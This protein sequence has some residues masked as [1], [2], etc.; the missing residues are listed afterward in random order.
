L[1]Q[2]AIQ[3]QSAPEDSSQ[4][5]AWVAHKGQSFVPIDAFGDGARSVFKLLV[6]LHTLVDSVSKDEP[7]LLIWE[8]PELF[9]NPKTLGLLLRELARLVKPKPI[10]L[11][12]ASHSLETPAHFVRLA[13]K[14]QKNEAEQ[15]GENEVIVLITRLLD[16]ELRSARFEPRVF[17]AWLRM[18]KDPRVPEGDADSPLGYELEDF[19]DG[20][21]EDRD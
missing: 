21:E 3:F 16:G 17:E 13:L 14:K 10:Q 5:Q 6:A 20:P 11:F 8:E 2:C 9:Q 1:E 4:S 15:L 19:S 12:I 18:H 7:G